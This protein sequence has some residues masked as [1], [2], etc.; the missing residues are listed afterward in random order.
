MSPEDVEAKVQVGLSSDIMPMCNMLVKLALV[1]L[2][3]GSNSGIESLDEEF[4]AD[5]YFWVNRRERKY[6]A[7]S[8]LKFNANRPT[9]LRWYGV[10]LDKNPNCLICGTL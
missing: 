6:K 10:H 3:R 5:Y 8:P 1:E 2:S 9:I 4:E 7:L